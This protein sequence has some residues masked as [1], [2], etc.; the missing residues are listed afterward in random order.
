MKTSRSER[1]IG[2]G[3][4]AAAL[5]YLWQAWSLPRFRL[6]VVVDAHVFPTAVGVALLAASL[7][8]AIRPGADAPAGETGDER[9]EGWS[10]PLVARAAAL[11]ALSAIYIWALEP[12]GFVVATFALLLVVPPLLGWRRWASAAVVA[13][14]FS[15]GVWYFFNHLLQVSLPR[16]LWPW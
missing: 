8:L 4:S 12:L 16:G 6:T 3:L 5:W 7:A 11:V 10:A 2:I 13:A 14:S 15:L 9:T 1:I